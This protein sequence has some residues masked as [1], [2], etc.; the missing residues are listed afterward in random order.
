MYLIGP[1]ILL[2]AVFFVF[3]FAK[4]GGHNGWNIRELQRV[5]EFMKSQQIIK[6]LKWKMETKVTHIN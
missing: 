3:T 6:S 4:N 1:W 2:N 5:S